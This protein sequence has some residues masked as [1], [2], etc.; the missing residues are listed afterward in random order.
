MDEEHNDFL[1]AD[2]LEDE[3]LQELYASCIL[4]ARIQTVANDSDAKPSYDSDFVDEVQDSSSSFL[5]GLFSYYDHEQS[6]HE[7]QE[8]IKSAYDD[9]QI[10]SNIIFDDP[11]EGVNSDNVEQDN[12][13]HDQQCAELE[14]LLRNVQLE[15][16]LPKLPI[17]LKYSA[18]GYLMYR[19]VEFRSGVWIWGRVCLVWSGSIMVSLVSGGGYRC[20]GVIVGV[21]VSRCVFNAGLEM[22]GGV[23]GVVVMGEVGDFVVGWIRCWGRRWLGGRGLVVFVG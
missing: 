16:N 9:D 6:H 14:S 3:E 5:K 17:I 10:D 2:V 13:V 21:G 12:N 11:D 15:C 22:W 23:S 18:L 19:V 4:M 7:Q 20:G 1:L 8:T